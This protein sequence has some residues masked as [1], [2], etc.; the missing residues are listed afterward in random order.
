M[1]NR[2]TSTEPRPAGH[3]VPTW[4]L[5]VT[6]FVTGNVIMMLEVVGT[7]VVG[8]FF[9]VGI[10]VWSALITVALLALA[11]GYWLG[12]RLADVR[13]GPET[14]YRLILISAVL[15]L[16]VPFLRHPVLAAAGHLG[17]RFGVLA[18][19]AVL[20]G[21]ALFL[22]GMVSPFAAKL[23]TDRLATLGRK[24]GSIYAI[25]TLGSFIG[26]LTMGFYLIPNFRLTTI[27]A[28]LGV[29]LLLLPAM[30]YM[31]GRTRRSLSA[32]A[33]LVAAAAALVLWP[34]PSETGWVGNQVKVLHKSTSFYGELKVIEK[35]QARILLVDGVSQSGENM[36]AGRKYPQ[37]IRD[38]IT[39][40]E[41]YQPAGKSVLLIGLGGGNLIRPLQERGF[42][43]DVVEIDKHI[44]EAAIRFFDVDPDEVRITLEDG[45]RYVRQT[46]RTYDA[47]VMNAFSGESSPT[48]LLSTEFLEEV[49][50]IMNPGGV[51]LVNFVS[52]VQG[53]HRHAAAALYHTLAESFAWAKTYFNYP[54]HRFSNVLFV[55][56]D[57]EV[58]PVPG[59]VAGTEGWEDVADARVEIYGWQD[60]PV[61][62]DEYNPLDFLNRV[63]Y[64]RW[65]EAIIADLGPEVLLD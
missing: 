63:T 37:Y 45:R 61:A 2:Q 53:P 19:S 36:Q 46:D 5:M 52:Y 26:T 49:K 10:Y 21:P 48:H 4:M 43:I 9:G 1:K 8:P 6:I 14:L 40:L 47:V 39:L 25:S 18:G 27:L 58:P 60:A 35:G 24:V 3:A 54:K 12:G 65:R 38:S 51:Y 34:R 15:T 59:E 64:R 30:Y 41:R 16:I 22:L 32:A 7:R 17:F 31:F 44:R 23:Y 62:T 56:G 42:R 50:T 28:G 20:F 57:G 11:A 55:A 33:L 13:P 29:V